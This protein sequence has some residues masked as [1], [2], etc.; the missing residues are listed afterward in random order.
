MNWGYRIALFFSCF[1]AF[2]IFMVIKCLQVDHEL[3]SPD[4]YAK[5]IAFQEQLN[6]QQN[7]KKLQQKPTWEI[8]KDELVIT[9]KDH[10]DKGEVTFFRPSD[11]ALDFTET[12]QLDSAQQ[13]SIS[14]SKFKKGIYRLQLSWED[15]S[16]KKYYLE[17]EIRIP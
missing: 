4:Y 12:L 17:K 11:G 15:N 3:V 1:V 5:E 14:L 8:T 7:V 6:Q 10:F 16:P 13:Q 2:M 9:I